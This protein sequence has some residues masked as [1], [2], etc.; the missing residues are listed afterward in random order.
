M[1]FFLKVII[2]GDYYPS[3]C[4]KEKDQ[5]IIISNHYSHVDTA[6]ILNNIPAS[7]VHRTHPVAARDYFA[8]N[9]LMEIFFKW[10]M[11]IVSID[12]QNRNGKA[13]D[14][15][16]AFLDLGKSLIIFPEG[17]RATGE[18]MNEFKLG[19]AKVLR[20]R[21]HIPYIPAYIEDSIKILPKGDPIV[22][23]HNFKLIFGEARYIDSD[24]SDIE[25]TETMK[26]KVLELK[27]KLIAR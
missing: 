8:K 10:T 9:K 1:R 26:Q 15:M 2:G 14:E 23:P 5:Y 19:V 13:I 4:L 24:K 27:D 17:S 11:N 25:N 6:A 7:K 22:I 16:V 12:R 3:S 18:E 20:Q 21:P